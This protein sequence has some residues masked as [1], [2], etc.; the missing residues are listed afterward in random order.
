MIQLTPP[1]VA[2]NTRAREWTKGT[3]GVGHGGNAMATPETPDDLE[4]PATMHASQ[5]SSWRGE[6][7]ITEEAMTPA[8]YIVPAVYC[9]RSPHLFVQPI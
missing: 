7:S 8:V 3:S 6:T 2:D 4:P 9:F 1:R 5:R